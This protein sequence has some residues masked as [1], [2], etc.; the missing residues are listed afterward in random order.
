MTNQ[1][2][3]NHAAH[4]E[5]RV[6]LRAE[7]ARKKRMAMNNR[8]LDSTMYV[9]SR[10]SSLAPSI[11]DVLLHAGVSRATFYK[12]FESLEQAFRAVGFR[13]SRQLSIG[14][15][16]LLSMLTDPVQR[17]CVG[18][19]ML[20]LRAAADWTWAGFVQRANSEPRDSEIYRL[21]SIDL[22]TG[23]ASGQFRFDDVRTTT[24]LIMGVNL[25]AVRGIVDARVSDIEIYIETVTRFT[26]RALSADASEGQQGIAF[27]REHL[28]SMARH[29]SWWKNEDGFDIEIE[30]ENA[31]RTAQS[32]ACDKQS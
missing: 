13:L 16:P 32:D 4:E 11:E 31:A 9:F 7:L 2:P 29:A 3:L 15:I 21:V 23:K 26:L 18:I 30:M 25:A 28:R 19:R 8:L 5:R 22:A 27:A 1:Q 6:D 24:D 10:Q 14:V 20:L 12:H 17:V